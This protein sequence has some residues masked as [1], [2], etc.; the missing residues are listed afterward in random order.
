MSE[1]IVT[2]CPFIGFL[3]PSILVQD[4]LT[5]DFFCILKVNNIFLFLLFQGPITYF[6]PD[7]LDWNSTCLSVE[8]SEDGNA[9]LKVL[10]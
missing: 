8:S 1:Q 3:S 6:Y 5:F 10:G 7:V 9:Y 2:F 4:F